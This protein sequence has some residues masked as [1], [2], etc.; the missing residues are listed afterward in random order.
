MK[1]SNFKSILPTI[2]STLFQKK[3]QNSILYSGPE[4]EN[5]N[6]LFLHDSHYDVIT[7]MPTFFVRKQYCHTCKKTY[8]HTGDHI[9]PELCKLCYFSNCPIDSWVPCTDC[10]RFFKSQECFDEH[11]KI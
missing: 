9:C 2:K 7:S 6:Y 8:D 11:K 4:K 5:K 1:L 10:N 3:I